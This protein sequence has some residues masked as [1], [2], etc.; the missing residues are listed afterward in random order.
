MTHL[1]IA[2]LEHAG[3]SAFAWT[4]EG[5]D[6]RTHYGAVLTAIVPALGILA[7]AATLLLA[8]L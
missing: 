6:G 1:E 8:I 5:Y 4:P 2:N 7:A 3:R